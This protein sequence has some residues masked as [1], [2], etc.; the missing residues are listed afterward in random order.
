MPAVRQKLH[1]SP[2]A[3]FRSRLYQF[4]GATALELLQAIYRNPQVPLP[5]RIRCATEALPYENPKLSAV[6]LASMDAND[7]AA[8]LDRAIMRSG[9]LTEG[10]ALERSQAE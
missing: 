1:L 5:V 6:A 10:K 7:F 2:C 4:E 3:D 8:R 9:K